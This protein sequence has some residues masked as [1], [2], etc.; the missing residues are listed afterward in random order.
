LCDARTR[1][2]R[3]HHLATRMV[4]TRLLMRRDL[5]AMAGAALCAPYAASYLTGGGALCVPCA[6]ATGTATFMLSTMEV[7]MRIV[8]PRSLVVS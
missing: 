6:I 7:G 8:V 2:R 3:A 4:R 1:N 5:S